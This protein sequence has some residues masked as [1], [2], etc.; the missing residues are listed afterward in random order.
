MIISSSHPEIFMSN[1]VAAD[2]P[3]GNLSKQMGSLADQLQM[4]YYNYRCD[5]AWR[6]AVNLYETAH[7]YLVCV[8]LAGV[9]KDKIDLEVHDGKL[10]LRGARPVPLES[11]NKSQERVSVHLMEIDHGAFCREVELPDDVHRDKIVANHRNGLL[12]I[13]LPKK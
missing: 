13:E 9:D 4:A 8:D 2:P 3:F 1:S 7:A 10:T 11:E 12:W 6:P 5:Q